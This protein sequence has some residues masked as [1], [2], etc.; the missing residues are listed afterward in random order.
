MNT[1]G[2]AVPDSLVFYPSNPV[3]GMTTG[4]V[5]ILLQPHIF[6][7]QFDTAQLD[8][9]ALEGANIN[10]ATVARYVIACASSN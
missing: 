5:Y 2:V 9:I 8:V 10:T 1:G 7:G 6:N 4:G 3:G